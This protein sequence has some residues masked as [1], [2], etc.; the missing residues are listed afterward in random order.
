MLRLQWPWVL[1]QS[2]VRS[3]NHNKCVVLGCFLANF[4][5]SMGRRNI[6]MSELCVAFG[7]D[8]PKW[9]WRRIV[10]I[11]LR[12]QKHFINWSTQSDSRLES[13]ANYLRLRQKHSSNSDSLSRKTI[14]CG[15][16]RTLVNC[17]RFAGRYHELSCFGCRLNIILWELSST[18]NSVECLYHFWFW[19]NRCFLRNKKNYTTA[20]SAIPRTERKLERRQH[21]SLVL[22]IYGS[23][24]CLNFDDHFYPLPRS[25]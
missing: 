15:K 21:T 13:T 8:R 23:V 6:K 5:A 12:A 25:F 19:T 17:I 3:I 11:A 24:F 1:L 10:F 14:W 22:I 16:N 4:V 20:H 18:R 9:W 7:M 2:F